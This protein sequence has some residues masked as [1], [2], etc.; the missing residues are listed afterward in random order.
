MILGWSPNSWG[1]SWRWL[2]GQEG[3]CSGGQ[4][5]GFLSCLE[6]SVPGE[7]DWAGGPRPLT[8]RSMISRNVL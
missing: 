8:W 3:L 2:E 1:E 4:E 6:R 5:A 7:G